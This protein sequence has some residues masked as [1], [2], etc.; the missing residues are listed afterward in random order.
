MQHWTKSISAPMQFN[1]VIWELP[2]RFFERARCK[3][4]RLWTIGPAWVYICQLLQSDQSLRCHPEEI[5]YTWLCLIYKASMNVFDK[6]IRFGWH[7]DLSLRCARMSV[8]TC[9]LIAAQLVLKNHVLLNYYY[10]INNI[11]MAY[12]RD[13]THVHSLIKNNLSYKWRQT[14]KR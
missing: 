7:A 4:I 3:L 11:H 12:W 5:L 8:R 10:L 9:L 13:N 1:Q 6:T 2:T 14:S